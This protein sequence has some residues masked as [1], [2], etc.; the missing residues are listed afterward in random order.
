MILITGKC[1]IPA[2]AKAVSMNVTAVTP[3][4]TGYVSVYPAIGVPPST[5]TVSFS[6]GQVRAAATVVGLDPDGTV[7]VYAAIPTGQVNVILD[8]NGYFQ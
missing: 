7:A 1:G 2:T 8:V 3:T 6:A 4:S 5:D